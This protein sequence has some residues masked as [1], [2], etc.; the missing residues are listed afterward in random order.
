MGP[1]EKTSA[2]T[3]DTAHVW[4]QVADRIQRWDIWNNDIGRDSKR[5]CLRAKRQ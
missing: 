2:S 1:E 5:H 4:D 3:D